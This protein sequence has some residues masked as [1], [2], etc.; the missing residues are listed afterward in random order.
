MFHIFGTHIY[1]EEG[2]CAEWF[3]VELSLCYII[4]KIH[5][6]FYL[7]IIYIFIFFL[8]GGDIFYDIE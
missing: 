1:T 5:W 4:N 6:I 7:Y 2:S 3:F 8:G